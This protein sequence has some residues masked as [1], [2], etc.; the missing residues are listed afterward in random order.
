MLVSCSTTQSSAGSNGTDEKEANASSHTQP[1][2]KDL[3][4]YL[5]RIPGISI[6]GSGSSARISVNG[7]SSMHTDVEPLIVVDGTPVGGGLSAANNTVIVSHIKSVRV[8]RTAS[9]VAFY[10]SQASSGV[11]LIALNH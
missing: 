8:L 3:V 11:I 5:R 10:G 2:V 7:M 9:E 4:E 1:E 6:V